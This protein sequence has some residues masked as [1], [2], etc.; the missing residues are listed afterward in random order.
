VSCRTLQL[1]KLALGRVLLAA[2]TIG[3]NDRISGPPEFGI[4]FEHFRVLGQ[5]TGNVAASNRASTARLKVSV[6][7]KPM[8]E[9]VCVMSH[10][11]RISSFDPCSV[12]PSSPDSQG[13]TSDSRKNGRSRNRAGVASVLRHDRRLACIRIP[14]GRLPIGNQ[15]QSR[16]LWEGLGRGNRADSRDRRGHRGPLPAPRDIIGSAVFMAGHKP[17]GLQNGTGP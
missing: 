17:C 14:D 11:W 15:L 3:R 6:R 7:P 12:T 10:P 4:R 16:C 8:P 9:A 5:S 1:R 2:R 13:W